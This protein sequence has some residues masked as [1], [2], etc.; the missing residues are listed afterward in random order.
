MDA[1]TN[2]QREMRKYLQLS[3]R[4]IE[5]REFESSLNCIR[6]FYEALVE[7][8]NQEFGI[9][10]NKTDKHYLNKC[11]TEIKKILKNSDRIMEGIHLTHLQE[12]GNY[13][14]HFQ[15]SNSKPQIEDCRY[16]L[17]VADS[18]FEKFISSEPVTSKIPQSPQTIDLVDCSYCNQ[19]IGEPCVSSSGR[20]LETPHTQRTKSYA[21]KFK[22]N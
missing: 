21:D 11:M 17:F 16:C 15:G 1:Y 12:W 8:L 19:P 6:K 20:K 22:E 7:E 14:S 18:F 10:F 4:Q 9:S 5:R 13:G 2:R 3:H